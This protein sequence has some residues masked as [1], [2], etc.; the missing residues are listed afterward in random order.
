MATQL[1]ENI[2]TSLNSSALPPDPANL[3]GTT[4][5]SAGK[6]TKAAGKT[7]PKK[8]QMSLL[9]TIP[10]STSSEADKKKRRPSKAAL[11]EEE[12]A[13]L[14]S[15]VQDAVDVVRKRNRL[16]VAPTPPTETSTPATSKPPPSATS[17]SAGPGISAMN[18]S[19]N[20]AVPLEPQLTTGGITSSQ[21]A[22]TSTAA[23]TSAKE[24]K[25]LHI[26]PGTAISE[27]T[28]ESKGEGSSDESSSD[29]DSDEEEHP[30]GD[31]GAGNDAALVGLLARAGASSLDELDM[32][33]VFRGPV[34]PKSKGGVLAEIA[35]ISSDENED[36]DKLSEREES[37]EEADK[38]Y[39]KLVKALEKDAP[40]SDEA[41]ADEDELVPPT[42]MDTD[43]Q[44]PSSSTPNVRLPRP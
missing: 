22:S 36:E 24:I 43:G 10:A 17:G 19:A 30:L 44:Q 28:M 4:P 15:A 5:Q 33:A 25:S 16:S 42:L 6:G 29:S 32:D 8:T 34:N 9:I 13:Q 20:S 12:Q 21:K 3:E 26:I 40:S 7:I 39:R 41:D 14:T 11:T 2:Q 35:Q 27:V 23:V 31:E 1:A 18:K 37:E 38:S